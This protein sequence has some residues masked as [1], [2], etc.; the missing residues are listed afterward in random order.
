M[1][2]I[3][4]R[5]F[6]EE[7]QSASFDVEAAIAERLHRD[8]V[9]DAPRHPAC[10]WGKRRSRPTLASRPQSP[11][12]RIVTG[13]IDAPVTQRVFGEEAQSASFYVKAAIAERLHRDRVIDAPVT[14]RVFGEEAQSASF[15]VEAT[16][17]ERSHRDRVIDAPIAQRVYGE[18]AQSASFDVEAAIAE[19]LH[20]DRVI[21]APVTQ[22]VFGGR[23]A[24]GQL[25][26]QG[27]NRR[28]FAL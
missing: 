12:V 22:R 13:V 2:P 16:I 21:D 11:S 9:I 20:R 14:Q 23:G 18:E 6:G 1:P 26:R 19:R 8:R 28:A 3:A 25:W 15:D 10:V 4:Q 17:A 7:A 5:V 24:V 27:H